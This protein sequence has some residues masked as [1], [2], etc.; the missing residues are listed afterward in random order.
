[1]DAEHIASMGPRSE[2]RGNI[3]WRQEVFEANMLQW[4]RGLKTAETV[5]K[6]D[7]EG[8]VIDASMG[9]R[10]ED[11][12]NKGERLPSHLDRPTL[13]WGRGLKTAETHDY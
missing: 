7:V 13:Q 5:R 8:L 3:V 11:R 4:G 2:D 12:G 10:S 1:M 9:P 6:E